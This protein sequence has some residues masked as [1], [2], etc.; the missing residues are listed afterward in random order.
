MI[1]ISLWLE[2]DEMYPMVMIERNKKSKFYYRVTKAS[3]KRLSRLVQRNKD[4][5]VHLASNGWTISGME[6]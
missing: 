3:R 4:Y 6:E 5:H 1:T 2:N